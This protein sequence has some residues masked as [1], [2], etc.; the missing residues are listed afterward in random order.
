MYTEALQR[1]LVPISKIAYFESWTFQQNNF[2]IQSAATT[3]EWLIEKSINVVDWPAKSR[4]MNPV[5]NI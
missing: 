3:K 5:E 4:D 1:Y 2:S